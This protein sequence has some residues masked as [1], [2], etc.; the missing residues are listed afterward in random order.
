VI[1]LVGW[2]A[3]L[4]D[5]TAAARVTDAVFEGY[6]QKAGQRTGIYRVR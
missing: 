2:P 6:E 1:H 5:K 4:A 3:C